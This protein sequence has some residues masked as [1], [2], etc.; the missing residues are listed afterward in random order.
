MPSL[1]KT[2][3]K[4]P[5]GETQ[6]E[7][8]KKLKTLVERFAELQ[9]LLYASRKKSL[10][11]ILQGMDA[12]GKDGAIRHVFSGI[13]PQG[14]AVKAFKTPT[15]EEASHDFLW[16]IYPHFPAKGMIQVFNRSHYEDILY[17][18]VHKTIERKRIEE[19]YKVINNIEK[20]LERNDTVI[21]KFYLH[22]S[23]EE[24]L[25]R[26]HER[27]EDPTKRWK[28]NPGDLGEA[29]LRKEFF[30]VYEELFDRC[31]DIP[32]HIIPADDKWYRNV[33]IAET[34]VNALENLK[35]KYPDV[36]A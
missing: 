18:T 36:V 17:P 6:E 31:N 28:Y 34:I 12:A 20:H 10:L 35:L 24:Q 29:K 19:R 3:T 21:L 13:N 32:W 11:V 22:V 4:A 26:L 33:L 5:K 2:D 8:E 15:E 30:A 25:K 7:A 27:W 14:C 23:A 1:S 16:R 9:E